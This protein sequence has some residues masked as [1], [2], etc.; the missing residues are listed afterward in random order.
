[1]VYE[2]TKPEGFEKKGNKQNTMGYGEKMKKHN[3]G[4][5]Y[6]GYIIRS[7]GIIFCGFCGHEF[8]SKEVI[9]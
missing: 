7:H 8:R 9:L 3:C 2:Q 6:Y 4:N 5:G 1:L